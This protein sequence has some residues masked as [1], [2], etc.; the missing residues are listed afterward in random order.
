MANELIIPVSVGGS[1]EIEPPQTQQPVIQTGVQTQVQPTQ[2]TSLVIPK[3]VG[4]TY[5][6]EPAPEPEVN[7]EELPEFMATPGMDA[8]S[9]GDNLRI[10]AG[11]M[12]APGDEAKKDIIRNNFEGVKIYEQGESTIVELPDGQKTVLNKPGLS[13]Q[14]VYSFLGDMAAFYGPS[15]LAG[16]GKGLMS[17]MAIGGLAAASTQVGLEK[18]AQAIGSEQDVDPRSVALAG[19]LGAGGEL[20]APAAKAIKG[21]ISSARAAKL[22]TEAEDVAEAVAGYTEAGRISEKSGIPLFRAQKTLDP[23]DIERQAFVA[24]LPGGAKKAAMEI[25]NQNQRAYQAVEEVLETIAPAEAVETASGRVRTAAQKAVDA[26]KAIRAERSSPLYKEAFQD[27]TLHKMDDTIG[28]IDSKLNE[29]PE[30]GEVARS[31]KKIRKMITP[32]AA[33]EGEEIAKGVRVKQLHNAKLEIDQM[34]SKIGEGSLGDTTKREILDIKTSLLDELEKVNP[35]YKTAREQFAKDSPAVTELQETLVGQ[36]S[37]LKETQLDSVS[38]KI[39]NPDMNPAV[40]R[41]TKKVIESQD[42]EAWRQIVRKHLEGQIGKMKADVDESGKTIANIPGQLYRNVFGNQKQK[43][44]LYAALDPDTAKS[45]R[46]IEEG[47]KRA[48]MGRPGG[49]QTAVRQVIE[50]AMRSGVA[51]SVRSFFKEPVK[52]LAGAGEE[53]IYGQK[54]RALSEVMFNPKWKPELKTLRKLKPES[55]EAQKKFTSILNRAIKDL[56]KPAAQALK[57]EQDQM[58]GVR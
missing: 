20:V 28:M 32:K 27:Q 24:T 2:Q 8:G 52:T 44:V 1:V 49:S 25:K 33:K 47:L 10:A 6:A 35:E 9:F 4:G 37:K 34:Y 51:R 43:K 5:Q 22:G 17:K 39:F 19:M 30:T 3:T 58:R 56:P 55:T 45:M 40:L 13:Y 29:F 50:R 15:K 46:Y 48:S 53:Y 42:P 36:I 31:L 7:V 38:K 23:T 12:M 54:V 11:M 14:D 18:G 57:P 21:R 41:K 26:K 16:F